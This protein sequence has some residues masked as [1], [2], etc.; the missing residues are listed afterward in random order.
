MNVLTW[1]ELDEE[2]RAAAVARGTVAAGPEVRASVT[3]TLAR[4]K[5]D[6]DQAVIAATSRF[7]GVDLGSLQVTSD[8]VSAAIA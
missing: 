8:D 3:D 7:D 5:A 6:G 4:V 1:T 2:A